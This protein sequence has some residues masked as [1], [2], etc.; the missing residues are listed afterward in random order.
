MSCF[1]IFFCAWLYPRNI[2][3]RSPNVEHYQAHNLPSWHKNFRSAHWCSLSP[4][5]VVLVPK[6]KPYTAS[7]L[8]T[9]PHVFVPRM[10]HNP[11]YTMVLLLSAHKYASGSNNGDLVHFRAL[12]DDHSSNEIAKLDHHWLPYQDREHQSRY[13]RRPART[14]NVRENVQ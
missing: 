1:A 11:A 10:Q 4:E 12:V 5:G 13:G 14:R 2:S 8:G 9:V 7:L 3:N 6:G